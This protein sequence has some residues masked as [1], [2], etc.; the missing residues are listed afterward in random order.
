MIQFIKISPAVFTYNSV[1]FL[2]PMIA[3]DSVWPTMS[4]RSPSEGGPG[5]EIW[6]ADTQYLKE[7]VSGRETGETGEMK[8]I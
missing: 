3:R 4:Q 5:G 8:R 6:Q 2:W 1:S 7:S